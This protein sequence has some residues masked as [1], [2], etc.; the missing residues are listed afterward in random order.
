M[1]GKWEA[2]SGLSMVEPTGSQIDILWVQNSWTTQ[3]GSCHGVH[4]WHQWPRWGEAAATI[5]APGGFGFLNQHEFILECMDVHGLVPHLCTVP[6]A[7]TRGGVP[8]GSQVV[9]CLA[10]WA[11][12]VRSVEESLLETAAA[13][14]NA[15]RE[16]Q[17]CRVMT[18][19]QGQKMAKI[20]KHSL[21]LMSTQLDPTILVVMNFG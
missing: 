13:A 5:S 15:E 4:A 17:D 9:V 16:L 2:D 1:T 19:L 3:A 11:P 18:L 7:L 6:S 20:I 12:E 14:S 8:Q 10:A 21:G